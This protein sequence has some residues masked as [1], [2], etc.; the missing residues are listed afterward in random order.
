MAYL[1]IDPIQQT[2]WPEPWG[3]DVAMAIRLIDE[4]YRR[5]Y[6]RLTYYPL[7]KEFTKMEGAGT[8]E[9]DYDVMVGASG[10]TAFDPL[11]DEPGVADAD[12]DW[13]QPHST[14]SGPATED[15]SDKF[16]DSVEVYG[17]I[18]REALDLDLKRWGFDRIR[19]LIC[20]IPLSILDTVG[21]S[22]QA[23]DYFE[24]DGDQYA[25]LQQDQTGFWKN[26]NVRLYITLNCEHRRQGS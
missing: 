5:H 23:G 4:E 17:R 19:D 8:Q 21:I 24:W 9:E 15:D 12:G 13:Q 11:Y 16:G 10:M 14:S 3:K 22:V 1:P 26:S 7:L 2:S 20:H 18:V 6:A 25:V